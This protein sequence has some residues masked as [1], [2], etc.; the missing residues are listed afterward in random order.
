MTSFGGN[1]DEYVTEVKNR[2]KQAEFMKKYA[3]NKAVAYLGMPPADKTEINRRLRQER[4]NKRAAKRARRARI[5]KKLMKIRMVAHTIAAA[6]VTLACPP[7][8]PA[9]AGIVFQTY[10]ETKLVE[11][12]S[13]RF[14][15][16]SKGPEALQEARTAITALK[17]AR[18]AEP[19]SAAFKARLAAKRGGRS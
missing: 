9:M 15:K 1:M 7:A 4:K 3:A 6:A 11:H 12:I 5:L 10:L 8:A 14:D 19:A 13:N 17:A 18:R 2:V 16:K